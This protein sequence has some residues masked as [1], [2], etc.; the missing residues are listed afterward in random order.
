M[1]STANLHP[2]TEALLATYKGDREKILH[3]AWS[4]HDGSLVTTGVKHIK[5][6][7]DAWREGRKIEKGAR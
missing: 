5:F 7:A 4:P 2:Y 3:I 6:V 1:V